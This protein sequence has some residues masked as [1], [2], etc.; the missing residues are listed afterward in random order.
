[1]EKVYLVDDQPIA[2]FI[3]RKLLELRG[4]KGSIRDFTDP[5]KALEALKEDNDAVVFLD[6]NM[7]EMNGWEFLEEL[8]K[9]EKKHDIIILTSSTSKCDQEKSREHPAVI[10]Y[11]VKPMTKNKIKEVFQL[12][13]LKIEDNS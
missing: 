6:L 1:M 10:K 8:Q 3:T 4:F 2:N 13:A 7:P 9:A 5:I 11:M 12:I